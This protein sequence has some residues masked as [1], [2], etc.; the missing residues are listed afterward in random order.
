MAA[1]SKK[2]K[3]VIIGTLLSIFL[4]VVILARL[5][6]AAFFSALK[7]IRVELLLLAAPLVMSNIVLRALRWNLVANQPVNQFKFFWQAAS[8]G[9][10]GNMIYPARAGEVL[11][12]IA[13]HHFISLSAG[14]AVTSAVI[15]RMV[16]M[17]VMGLF[18]LLVLWIHG[19]RVDPS[20]G[21]SVIALFVLAVFA[22][23][24]LFIFVDGLHRQAQHWQLSPKWQSL[25]VIYLH[26]LEGIQAFRKAHNIIFA[27]LITL[28]AFISD[29]TL[30][31]LIMYAFGWQLPLDA[32]LTV[33]IF[34][35]LGISLP[36][37]PGYIGVYQVAC[38]L[39]LGL[40][41][42]EETPAVA[43]SIVLQLL[44]F[45]VIGIQ[46]AI[47]AT[48]CGFNLSREKKQSDLDESL[49]LQEKSS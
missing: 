8:I 49:Q 4:L 45:T 20:V 10:L 28:T 40:Y 39:A 27:L 7:H 46:G 32:A 41:G 33:G 2:H 13:I 12:I 1:T 15:D 47:V 43:Y 9:Y 36:S 23:I 14:R 22:L 18:T 38:V 31:G 21:V 17:I 44:S 30:A 6:W 48:Y 42:I 29:Y 3:L 34:I 26:A 24:I 37:A 19:N 11:R 5:D 25:Q 16:D 35:I